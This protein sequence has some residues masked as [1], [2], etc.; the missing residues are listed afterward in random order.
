MQRSG[1]SC[2]FRLRVKYRCNGVFFWGLLFYRMAHLRKSG[3]IPIALVAIVC[4][5]EA[6]VAQ[7]GWKQKLDA[8]SVDLNEDVNEAVRLH[9]ESDFVASL[10]FYLR[11]LRR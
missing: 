10:P 6:S 3:C 2:A 4:L 7:W 9:E 11:A 5:F 8:A 1:P